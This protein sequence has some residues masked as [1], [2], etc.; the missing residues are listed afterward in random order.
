MLLDVEI[1]A[2]LAL[3]ELVLAERL[4]QLVAV[5]LA[6]EKVLVLLL[7]VLAETCC[8]ADLVVVLIVVVVVGGRA[9]T[10][11]LHLLVLIAEQLALSMLVLAEVV[12]E[13]VE[14]GLALVAL[15]KRLFLVAGVRMIEV[16]VARVLHRL[17]KRIEPVGLVSWSELDCF[18]VYT[19]RRERGEAVRASA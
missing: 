16:E 8:Q 10:V 5:E 2:V 1:L 18:S 9:I 11:V 7:H 12:L 3:D 19:Q 15:E 4:E 6:V 17:A 14:L 13:G